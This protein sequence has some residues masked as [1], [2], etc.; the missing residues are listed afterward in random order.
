MISWFQNYIR[1][2][3]KEER[4]KR[5]PSTSYQSNPIK[6]RKIG[7]SN[8]ILS[9]KR[10]YHIIET[11]YHGLDHYNYKHEWLKHWIHVIKNELFELEKYEMDD[12]GKVVIIQNEKLMF[13]FYIVYDINIQ[14]VEEVVINLNDTT[15]E[16]SGFSNIINSF[17]MIL[18][19]GTIS[20]IISNII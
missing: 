11:Y 7:I 1:K 10:I 4:K 2:Y 8:D 17:G 3:S 5:F 12:V 6:I 13:E 15:E 18:S 9:P 14:E 19:L 16:T 20:Y